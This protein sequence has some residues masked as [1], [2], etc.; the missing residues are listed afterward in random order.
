MGREEREEV[1]NGGGGGD[2]VVPAVKTNSSLISEAI[3]TATAHVATV[4]TETMTATTTTKEGGR[5]GGSG[6]GGGGGGNSGGSIGTNIASAAAV[7]GTTTAI[8]RDLTDTLGRLVPPIA[9][10]TPPSPGRIIIVVVVGLIRSRRGRIQGRVGILRRRGH[11]VSFDKLVD[12]D[13]LYNV[14]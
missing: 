5:G 13:E 1:G 2:D 8:E 12:C 4:T 14:V 6:G 11:P 10:E 7:K 9:I 3:V